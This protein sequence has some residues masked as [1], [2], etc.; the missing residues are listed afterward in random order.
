MTAHV[1]E[2]LLTALHADPRDD[3][4]W[5]V[6]ADHL[7]E[8]GDP[9]SE[10]LRLSRSLR[11]EYPG[12]TRQDQEK[13]LRELL[14]SGVRPCVPIRTNS[15]GMELVLIPPGWVRMGAPENDRL[16][17]SDEGPV[18]KV[19]ISRP[20]YLGLYPVT[21]AQFRLF[22]EKTDYRTQAEQE[23]GAYR[24]VQGER[25]MGRKI[26]WRTPGRPPTDNQPVTCVSWNDSL[27]FLA[28]LSSLPEERTAG[29]VYRLPT[30][31][32]W[33]YACRAGSW[34]PF[35]FGTTL[36]TDQ[37]NFD[38]R[39]G[40]DG[41]RGKCD[42]PDAYRG[43]PTPVGMFPPN[44]FG[45]FDVLG[46]VWEWCSDWHDPLYHQRSA[47]I[48]PVGPEQGEFRVLRGGSWDNDIQYCRSAYRCGFCPGD[49]ANRF[50]LRVACQ[51]SG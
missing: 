41:Y 11:Q 36:S 26:T 24:W 13:R 38:G 51:V 15:I 6:L 32:E 17:S 25:R 10:V 27:A 46:N 47:R 29:R 4:T 48:D 3:T 7:E 44:A 35:H 37:A 45:L 34:T 5:L 43:A 42:G 49:R 8:L 23:G 30:E 28:W 9:R 20:F 50:G 16:R 39:S 12:P 18:R 33:E 31:A 2:T 14:A 19:G 21:V 40:G 22:V 1:E